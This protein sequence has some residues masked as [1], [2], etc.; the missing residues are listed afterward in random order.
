MR[1]CAV[2]TP[3][4]RSGPADNTPA[5]RL[6]EALGFDLRREVTFRGFRVPSGVPA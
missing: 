5:I 3:C 1:P 4:S 2:R 6:Y